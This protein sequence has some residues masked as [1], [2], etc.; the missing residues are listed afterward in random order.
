MFEFADPTLARLDMLSVRAVCCVAFDD[1]R[2]A[3]G[4]LS[5]VDWRLAGA[6]SRRMRD[7]FIS[8]AVGERVLLGTNGKFP[9]DKVVVVGAGPKRA[10]D[11][12]AFEA[13]ATAT[14]G[15]LAELEVHEA[16]WELPGVPTAVP[17][18]AAFERLVPCMRR[19]TNLDELTLL[20]S[21]DLAKPLAVVLERD[22]RKAQSI[23]P[24][25]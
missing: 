14:F 7:G 23:V 1:E 19:D 16:A 24:P 10:F 4:V 17:A 9:F 6:V 22:R 11:V 21:P 13:V 12:D 25:G 2:P 5:L 20:G 18:E 3:G 15:V 8:G